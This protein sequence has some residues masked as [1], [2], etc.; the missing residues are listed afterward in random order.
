MITA[1]LGGLAVAGAFGLAVAIVHEA[2]HETLI[3]AALDYRARRYLTEFEGR[4]TRGEEIRL[5][6]PREEV[7]IWHTGLPSVWSRLTP[8]L[9]WRRFDRMA[10]HRAVHILV[11]EGALAFEAV[12]S[13]DLRYTETYRPTPEGQAGLRWLRSIR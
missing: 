5:H 4:I 9:V 6:W 13:G 10:R 11:D 3:T 7:Q 1:L 8:W 12:S 2:R